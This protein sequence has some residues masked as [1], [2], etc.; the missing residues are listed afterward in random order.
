[1][2]LDGIGDI[3]VSTTTNGYSAQGNL[4]Q[5]VTEGLGGVHTTTNTYDLRGNLVEQIIENDFDAD[6][7]ADSR[8]TTTSSYDTHENLIEQIIE[9]DS[10]ADGTADSVRTTTSSFDP[11][12]NLLERIFEDD[13]DGDGN[14]DYI[15]RLTNEYDPQGNLLERT[16][17]NDWDGDGTVDSVYTKVNSY[18]R[19]GNLVTVDESWGA[20]GVIYSIAT[21]EN[22]YDPQ[23]NHLTSIR[24]ED[25]DVDGVIDFTS[26]EAHTYDPSGKLVH[27]VWHD[28]GSFGPFIVNSTDTAIYDYDVQGNL[29][30]IEVERDFDSDGT[31]DGIEEY[32]SSYDPRGNLLEEGVFSSISAFGINFSSGHTATLSYDVRGDLT[33]ALVVDYFDEGYGVVELVTLTTY[34]VTR[35]RH[36]IQFRSNHPKHPQLAVCGGFGSVAHVQYWHPGLIHVPPEPCCSP[37][38]VVRQHADPPRAFGQEC[39]AMRRRVRPG[40]LDRC[41]RVDGCR[42][43]R[44][45]PIWIGQCAPGVAYAASDVRFFAGP[46]L[47]P[48]P[49]SVRAS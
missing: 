5:S 10:D 25:Y 42:P 19:Q 7:T 1:M 41:S 20:P 47:P 14:A 22:T 35:E 36:V 11:Q 43:A 18:D 30:G 32:T 23:G 38:D 9:N 13:S 3:V 24:E 48:T 46:W 6:G 8:R 28:S 49:P 33:E 44:Q 17:E 4:L 12:R 40:M 27:S 31:V 16:S 29:I 15:N 21:T 45:G 26:T 34:S 2:D 39:S 37:A